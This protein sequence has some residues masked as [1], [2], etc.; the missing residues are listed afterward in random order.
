MDNHKYTI[1]IFLIIFLTIQWHK[2]RKNNEDNA[3]SGKYSDN[4]MYQN[5]SPMKHDIFKQVT[6][7]L[8]AVII[9]GLASSLEIWNPDKPVD[10]IIGRSIISI[11][12]YVVYYQFIQ[13]YLVNSLP[14]F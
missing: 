13:P 12:G 3:D 14:N 4:N 10:S 9:L 8:G 6:V 7:D 2:N 1:L 11:L 5:I